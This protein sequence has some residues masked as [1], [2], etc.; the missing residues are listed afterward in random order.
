M[1]RDSSDG[2]GE[3]EID[4]YSEVRS[5][6]PLQEYSSKTKL[7]YL[8][9]THRILSLYLPIT[10]GDGA[11]I[12]PKLIISAWLAKQNPTHAMT[13]NNIVDYF[14]VLRTFL[15][16]TLYA[17]GL[18]A[19]EHLKE[20]PQR[21]KTDVQQGFVLCGLLSVSAI[22]V[23][24]YNKTLLEGMGQPIEG[25]EFAES[26]LNGYYYL[27]PATFVLNNLQTI[28]VTIQPLT[29]TVT[30]WLRAGLWVGFSYP[31]VFGYWSKKN[32][33]LLGNVIANT[34]SHS[35]VFGGYAVY[36]F[37]HGTFKPFQ[38][39]NCDFRSQKFKWPT[40]K[41]LLKVGISLSLQSMG[42]MVGSVA[43]TIFAGMLDNPP[44]NKAHQIAQIHYFIYYTLGLSMQEAA[45]LVTTEEL[46]FT[47]PQDTEVSRDNAKRL[48]NIAI[49]IG[50]MI[51]LLA[52]LI[53][54][55]FSD[56]M[57]RP[58]N[59][60]NDS[61]DD[62]ITEENTQSLL[63]MMMASMFFETIANVGAGNLRGYGQREINYTMYTTAG[64]GVINILSE[65]LLGF[66]TNLGIHGIYLGRIIGSVL[67]A[68][69]IFGRWLTVSNTF[70]PV[71]I[72]EQIIET[73]NLRSSLLDRGAP[74]ITKYFENKVGDVENG[75]SIATTK[76]WLT[77]STVES[78]ANPKL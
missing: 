1:N 69:L 48:G 61:G 25:I 6:I 11:D 60:P 24:Y 66:K 38:I 26:A 33:G 40:L 42:T 56:E 63:L 9:A 4:T 74:P 22:P 5:I 59:D 68:S 36:M 78:R 3:K 37:K 77:R 7:S 18:H 41:K 30:S 20:A 43:S 15:N 10:F 70:E 2:D 72:P 32:E 27:L 16:K 55:F 12:G 14:E 8:G 54:V 62:E 23:V 51:P 28:G 46:T 65:W 39:F 29:R 57:T 44:I 31:L 17:G 19:Q 71:P 13:A 50:S 52:S 49:M 76:V 67:N 73:P 47:N 45:G 58:F 34:I 64:T 75:Q 21:I 35:I 53:Y